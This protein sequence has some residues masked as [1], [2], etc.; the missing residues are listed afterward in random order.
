MDSAI[1]WFL[2][3]LGLI[4]AELAIPG[5]I[6]VFIGI[7]AW[8]VAILDWCG[9][10]SFSVQLWVFGLAS[11]G[12]VIFARRYVK[13]WFRGAETTSGGGVDEEFLGKIVTVVKPIEVG[14][15]GTVELKGA[16]W[17]AFSTTAFKEGDR[18]EVVARDNITLEVKSRA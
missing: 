2:I 1:I 12:L 17:K 9:V 14:D 7:A 15:F 11:L 18:V 13:D 6:L 10:D 8:I 5:V 4:V 3:G 16:Q